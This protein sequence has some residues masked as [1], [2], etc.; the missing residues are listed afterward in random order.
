[1]GSSIA[2]LNGRL[3]RS[4]GKLLHLALSQPRDRLPLL[5]EELLA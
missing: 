1:M 2:T 4:K 5:E 3:P